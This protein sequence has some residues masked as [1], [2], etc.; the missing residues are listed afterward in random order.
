MSSIRCHC[1]NYVSDSS[2]NVE[3]I[4]YFVSNE[5][6]KK[7]WKIDGFRALIMILTRQNRN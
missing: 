2:D 3:V 4:Y 1:G 5:T 6:L 7:H